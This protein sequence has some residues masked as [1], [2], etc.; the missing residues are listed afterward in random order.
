[1]KLYRFDTDTDRERLERRYKAKSVPIKHWRT[2][3]VIGFCVKVF[4]WNAEEK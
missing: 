2:G 3:K 4:R 1:M